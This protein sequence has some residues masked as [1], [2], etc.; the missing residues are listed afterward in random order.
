MTPTMAS[1]MSRAVVGL[2]GHGIAGMATSAPGVVGTAI[3]PS[4]ADCHASR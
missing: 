4:T 3:P 2:G 1:V